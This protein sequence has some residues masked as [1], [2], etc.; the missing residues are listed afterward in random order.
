VAT[1]IGVIGVSEE[2]LGIIEDEFAEMPGMRL[3]EGQF[4]RLWALPPTEYRE[5]TAA[6]ID[7]GVITRDAGGRYCRREDLVD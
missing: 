4:Q 3:T 5:V 6:L 2:I 1:V 7:R